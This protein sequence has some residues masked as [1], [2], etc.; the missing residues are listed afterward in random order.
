M[1]NIKSIIIDTFK[2][3]AEKLKDDIIDSFEM[4]LTEDCSS[5]YWQVEHVIDD[6]AG[7]LEFELYSKDIID[8]DFIIKDYISDEDGLRGNLFEILSTPVVNQLEKLGYDVR[9]DYFWETV[10]V[11]IPHE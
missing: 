1:D 7:Q 8:E 2:E 10:T 4:D 5:T 11:E 9:K 3:E 6:I